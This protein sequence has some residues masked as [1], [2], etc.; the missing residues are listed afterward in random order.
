[1]PI[2]MPMPRGAVTNP[3][4]NAGYCI[5]CSSISGSNVL[6]LDLPVLLVRLGDAL[7]CHVA[8]SWRSIKIGTSLLRLSAAALQGVGRIFWFIR[9]RLSGSYFALIAASRLPL[10]R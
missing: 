10:P 5:S 8:H 9:N 4:V 2:I 6:V 7:G 3:V 1:M